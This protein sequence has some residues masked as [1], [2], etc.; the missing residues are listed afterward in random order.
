[1]LL[2]LH[3]PHSFFLRPAA[4]LRSYRRSNLWPDLLA[5]LTVAVIL[6]PQG[7]A[8]A[9]IAELPPS[10]GLYTAIVAA[11]VGGIWGSSN[12]LQTGTTNATSLLVLSI[13][14]PIARPDS[15][16]FLAAA[17]LLAVMAGVFR[18][19]MGLARL[20]VL[21]NFVSESVI[22]GYT[23]GAGALIGANQ[24]RHL[25]R[26]DFAST[27][28]V[29]ETVG[30]ILS[31]LP[32]THGTSL[33]LGF[34]LIL[35]LLLLRRFFP[36]MP[37]PLIGIVGASALVGLLGLQQQG[38]QVIGR[39]PRSLPPLARLPLLDLDL[40]RQLATGALAMAAI[41]LVEATSIARSIANETGQRLD[42]NQEFVGQGL[43]N[44]TSG[45]LSGYPCSG[46]FTRSAVN[47]KAGAQ[48]PLA[49]VFSGL[50]V[51]IAMIALAPLAAYVPR[52]ALAGVLI[53]TAYGMI[54]R[55][56]IAR[57]WRGTRGDAT[58]MLVTFLATL[59]LPLEFAVLTGILISFGVYIMKTSVPQ[60]SAVLPDDEFRHLV[61]Q[62]QKPQCPQLGIIEILGDVYFGA[63]GHI[64]TAI[65][66][67]MA[68]NP[69]QRFLLLRM[70]SVEHCDYSG[71]HA[72]ESIVDKYRDRGGDVFMMR[73][74]EP[75]LD[76]MKSTGFLD[77]LRADHFLSDDTAISH[78]FYTTLDPAVCIY[79][80]PVRAF[81][82]CQNLPKRAYQIDL[83]LHTEIL[84]DEIASTT[85]QELWQQLHDS[86]P[87]L[88]VDV[89]EPR[90]FKRG[91]VPQAQ[92]VPLLTLL[93]GTPELPRGRRVVVVC[94]SGRR[95]VRAAGLL[96]DQGY[97][98][99]VVLRGGMLAWEA[100]GLLNA[101]GD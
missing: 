92:L 96:H 25:L 84:T 39:L 44:I 37:G 55:K 73:V 63:V 41:G 29:G 38:V 77:T 13:L 85:S 7:M 32:E 98:N 86:M 95:S 20:G 64:E 97:D 94:Q 101:I 81:Q 72:L 87:P 1:M 58:I 8:H 100:A 59:L 47:Y 53:V 10:Y 57:I 54:N 49:S 69:E 31:H 99:V 60:V 50:F 24:L 15:G 17:G 65:H 23:A 36:R 66:Q 9:L 83:P 80:C 21:V 14:L 62:P 79:E 51:L 61:H 43:A 35:L 34:S 74:Q 75:V 2:E 88:V 5:G 76:L 71:I 52:T 3:A 19:V 67:H 12:Q 40:V 56:E 33:T 89:R 4:I 93:S 70:Y 48:T 16:E 30:N 91:H 68:A 22:V 82:E 45:F 90:E 78:L 28:G 18:L 26:L 11:I 6:L 46:S 42:S 27:P